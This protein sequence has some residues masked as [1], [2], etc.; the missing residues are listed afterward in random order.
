[1]THRYTCIIQNN[2][3]DHVNNKISHVCKFKVT[4]HRNVTSCENTTSHGNSMSPLVKN[5]TTRLMEIYIFTAN[6]GT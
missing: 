6:F 1:M 3:T 2:L 5:F 4:S